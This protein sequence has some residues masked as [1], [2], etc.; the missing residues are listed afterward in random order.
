MMGRQG[1]VLTVAGMLAVVIAWEIGDMPRDTV[2]PAGPYGSM[3]T[4]AAP[5]A[6]ADNMLAWVGP[7]LARPLFSPDRRP[8]ANR[9]NV[10]AAGVPSLPRLTGILVGPFGRSAIFAGRASKPIV[11]GEGGRIDAYTVQSI[12]AAQVR[13]DGPN[14]VQRL[15]P[16]FDRVDQEVSAPMGPMRRVGQAVGSR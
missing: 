4:H 6:H 15:Q 12:D 11:L 13:L 9:D 10:A 3:A 7:I 16:A 2:T 1:A 14:G 8:A 5:R